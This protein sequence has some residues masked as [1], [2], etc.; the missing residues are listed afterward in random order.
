MSDTFRWIECPSWELD[1]FG[2]PHRIPWPVDSDPEEANR[3][4]LDTEQL[5]RAIG[6]LGAEAEEPWVSYAKAS[7]YFEDLSEAMEDHEIGRAAEILEKMEAIRPGTAFIR[8]HQAHLA[9]QEGDETTAARLYREAA[10][11]SPEV[12]PIWVNLGAALASLGKRDEAIVAFREALKRNTHEPLALEGLASLREVVKLKANDPENDNAF[13]YLDIPSFRNIATQQIERMTDPGA[14][15][16]YAD[17]LLRD[18]LVPDLGILALERANTFAPNEPRILFMLSG[19]YFSSGE[20]EK[21]H[22][23][24]LQFTQQF[25]EDPNGYFRLAQ[26]CNARGDDAGERAALEKTLE[27]EPNLQHGLAARFQLAPDEHDPEKENALSEFGIQS[28]SWMA[29][30]MAGT[31]ARTRGDKAATLLH[32]ERAL[33][34]SPETEEVLLQYSSALGE[35]REIG[36][37]ATV[38]RPAVESGKYSK[39]LDWNYAQV[40]HEA[41]MTKDAIAVV[42][43]A[44]KD[45]PDD[46]K[47]MAST[48]VDSWLGLVTGCGVRLEVNPAGFLPRPLLIT[49]A[50]GDGGVVMNFGERL[51]AHASF[52]WRTESNEA[53]VLL[54]QGHTGAKEPR[55]L[56]AFRMLGASADAASPATLECNITAMPDGS[57]HF[58]ANQG[59]RK[60]PVAWFPKRP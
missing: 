33:A 54:Q 37:L 11:R 12:I 42:A 25:P 24:S 36:K 22:A 29:H 23:I 34:I 5:H 4:S 30:I 18:G 19:A 13:V 38:I 32:A 50:D 58:R 53:W 17:Q 35:T 1:F 14:M 59:G 52:P 7:E 39:R 43:K 8:F 26:M 2:L 10:A 51:P 9:R 41:G 46:F 6:M 20:N 3:E 40:L 21:A 48:V 47:E 44:A 15:V 56:G 45:A 28:K 55:P 16:G 27:I 31:I 57:I 49:L 60:L